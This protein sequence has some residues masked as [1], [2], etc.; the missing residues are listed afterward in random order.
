M[1]KFGGNF[2]KL[3]FFVA[4]NIFAVAAICVFVE[5]LASFVLFFQSIAGTPPVAERSHTQYDAELG[6]VN[7]PD[8]YIEN[9]YG[10]GLHL[11]TNA[12]GFRSDENFSAAVPDDKLRAI[13]SGDSFTLG[14]GMANENTWCRYLEKLADRLQTV[15]MGQGGYGVDQ[16]YLWYKR[17]GARLEHDLHLFT[18][19]TNDFQRMQQ[20]SFLGYGK[21]H[22][23]LRDN[24]LV[25]EN[26]P[27]PERAFYAPWL[28][29]NSEALK[30][31]KVTQLLNRFFQ[32]PAQA[33]DTDERAYQR[34]LAYARIA[35]KML[36]E[37]QALNA[38]HDS[39]LVLIYLPTL[40]DHAQPLPVD[41][42][43]WRE[44][45]FRAAQEQGIIFIDLITDFQKLPEARVQELFLH[46]AGVDFPGAAGHYSAAGNQYIAERIYEELLAIPEVVGRLGGK[47]RKVSGGSE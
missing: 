19:I 45:V 24:E 17:D 31:L 30:Q 5:G 3:V 21:P 4:F 43:Q 40:A 8:I 38:E 11:R 32:Q 2:Q 1:K 25:V 18:F 33:A 26:V 6:W 15:N 36:E 27:V 9:L 16:A 35:A 47:A 37:L 44:F 7:R 42:Q 10:P 20:D 22:L 34:N 23:N 13:C 28:T 46:E 12:Q 29:Q 39:V 14:Y 41:T